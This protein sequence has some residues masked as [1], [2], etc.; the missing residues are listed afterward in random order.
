MVWPFKQKQLPME[1][2]KASGHT[3]MMAVAMGVALPLP[4]GADYTDLLKGGL[5]GRPYPG[6]PGYYDPNDIYKIPGDDDV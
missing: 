3:L 6:Y 2:V 4:L 5:G 1:P